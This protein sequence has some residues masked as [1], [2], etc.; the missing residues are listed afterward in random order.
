MAFIKKSTG[1]ITL[2]GERPKAVSLS[3]GTRHRCLL[4]TLLFN[5]ALEVLVR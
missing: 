1:N 4:S 3:S 2:S 5:S